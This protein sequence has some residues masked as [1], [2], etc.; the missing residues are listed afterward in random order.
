MKSP[1]TLWY[2]SA[3]GE[4]HLGW[5]E[6]ALPIGN[7]DLGCKIFGGIEKERIQFNEKSLWKG[8][9]LGVGENSNGNRNGD[10]GKSVA[11]IRKLLSEGKMKEAQEH[12]VLLQGDE[13][14]LGAYQSFGDLFI[15]FPGLSKDNCLEYERGLSMDTAVAWVDFTKNGTTYRRTFFASYPA[16]TVVMRFEG[17]RQDMELSL[18]IHQTV[19]KMTCTKEGITL[20]G[21]VE[22]EADKGLRFALSLLAESDGEVSPK[23]HGLYI[24]NASVMTLYLAAATDYGWDYPEYRSCEPLLPLVTERTKRA[25]KKGYEALYEEHQRDYTPLFQRVSL[26]IGQEENIVPTDELLSAYQQG[27][28]SPLL[29]YQ[30]FQYGRYLILA[31]SRAEGLP[32][33]L[34]GVWNDSNE[35]EWQ[36]DYHLNINLQMNYWLSMNTNLP[37]TVPPLLQYVNKCLVIPGRETAFRYT[38]IGDGNPFTPTGWMAHTQNNIFG[39]TGPGSDWKWGWA[40]AVGAFLL[41]NTYEYFRFTRDFDA[42]EK[43]IYPAMEEA[44]RMWSQLLLEESETGELLC[45]PCFSPEQ[46]PVTAGN[47]FDQ[48]MIWQLYHDVLEAAEELVSAGRMGAVDEELIKTIRQQF[49][50]I[51]P[52]TVGAWGQ[53]KEWREEDTWENRGFDSM[54]VQLHHRHFSH[55]MGVYPGQ[56]ITFERPEL[57]KAAKVS[58]ED[59]GDAGPSWSMALRMG[60]WARLGEGN[61]CYQYLR[62]FI[63]NNTMKNLWSYHPPFQIDGN[64]GFSAGVGEMLLQSHDR[65]IR[66]LPALPDRWSKKGS[67]RGLLAR[68]N[69]TVDAWWEDG[70]ITR[71]VLRAGSDYSFRLQYNGKELQCHMKAG[72]VRSFEGE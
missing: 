63:Q 57:R 5:E 9:T 25:A 46:G 8:T 51:V 16:K 12:M 22:E 24:K 21:K 41:Q 1:L 50:R 52:C 33:N 48:T 43:E 13:T 20:E 55:L 59:R 26:E 71:V 72:E 35:P 54:G 4:G 17:E 60:V 38:G 30:M 15:E 42:L 23:E 6:D 29:E 37:E 14:G 40:P 28:E 58:M 56:Y 65:C 36:S 49:P 10:Y 53:I 69:V 44:A 32:A 11:L 7:G 3:S 68:G 27:K 2:E 62:F 18:D 45:S 64:L 31:S 66:I 67:F 34:Q 61:S 39:H 70:Q 47:T 19:T